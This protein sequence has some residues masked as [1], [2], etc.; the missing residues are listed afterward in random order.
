MFQ[1]MI[2]TGLIAAVIGI[3][4]V[5]ATSAAHANSS[6]ETRPGTCS[7]N[8]CVVEQCVGGTCQVWTNYYEWNFDTN[9]WV[10]LFTTYEVKQRNPLQK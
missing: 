8:V 9:S 1:R 7:V 10:L 3:C 4:A 2:S 6:T 5:V